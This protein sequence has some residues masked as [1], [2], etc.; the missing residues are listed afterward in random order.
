[1]IDANI[2]AERLL[3]RFKRTL[4]RPALNFNNKSE[5][6]S[7]KSSFFIKSK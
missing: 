5:K 1:M 4:K 7:R 2:K 3:E 6:F